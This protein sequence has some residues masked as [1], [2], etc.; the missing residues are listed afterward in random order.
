[1]RKKQ[2]VYEVIFSQSVYDTLHGQT[3]SKMIVRPILEDHAK[4]HIDICNIDPIQMNL[5]Q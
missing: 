4:N 3:S 2:I 5:L 1:M